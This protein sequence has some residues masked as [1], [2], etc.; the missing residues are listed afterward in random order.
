MCVVPQQ[1]LELLMARLMMCQRVMPTLRLALLRGSQALG[2]QGAC[3]AQRHIQRG[4]RRVSRL[5]IG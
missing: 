1:W 3:A 5:G 2:I 4:N